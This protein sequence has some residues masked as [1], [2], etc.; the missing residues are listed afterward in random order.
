MKVD[1]LIRKDQEDGPFYVYSKEVKGDRINKNEI[2]RK[3]DKEK[4]LNVINS[5]LGI[6][7]TKYLTELELKENCI[8]WIE[9]TL[10]NFPDINDKYMEFLIKDFTDSMYTR[11]REEEKYV[12]AIVMKNSLILCHSLFGEKTIT[13]N[14][15]VIERML[16]RDNVIRYVHFKKENDKIKVTFFEDTKSVFFVEWLG[17]PEKEAFSYLGG[18]NRIFT[19]IHGSH[20][21]FEFTDEDFEKKV[22]DGKTFRI[23]GNQIILPEPI[24]QLTISQVRVGK[25]PYKNVEDFIQDFLAKRYDLNYYQ[26]E[27]KKLRNSL[28]PLTEKLID[29]EHEVRSKSKIYIKKRNPNFVV[30]FCDDNIEIRKSFL[31]KIKTKVLNREHIRLFHAGMD[32]NP[33]PIKIKNFEIYNHVEDELTSFLID[34]YNSSSVGDNLEIVI[35]YTIFELLSNNNSNEPISYFFKELKNSLRKEMNFSNRF[36]SGEDQVLEL[37]SRDF[38]AGNN[39]EIIKRLEDDIE[40]K[41]KESNFKI[42]IIGADEKTKKIETISSSRFDDSRLESIEKNLQKNLGFAKIKM[43]RVPSKE[44]DDCIIVCCVSREDSP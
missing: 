13:P 6:G 35:L 37:K 25:K 33:S 29:D 10:S 28:I 40:K 43:I 19:E 20:L 1:P 17:L 18:K 23:E 31:E 34:Y 32:L 11:M 41:M 14:L 36:L 8:E 7:K 22:I 30:L 39:T 4:F 26:E 3:V 24:R 16:D 42:Y 21:V 15:Q 2:K 44:G 38:I 27:Y 9:S 12:V 5:L